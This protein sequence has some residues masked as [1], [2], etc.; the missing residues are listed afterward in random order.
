MTAY[1]ARDPAAASRAVRKDTTPVAMGGIED[2]GR[3]RRLSSAS[4][5]TKAT[6]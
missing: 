2:D 3:Q 1:G 5:A 6:A 4:V